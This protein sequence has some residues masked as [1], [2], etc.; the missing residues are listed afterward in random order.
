MELKKFL[1]FSTATEAEKKFTTEA[2]IKEYE[3]RKS[4]ILRMHHL[5]KSLC[6]MNCRASNHTGACKAMKKDIEHL[7]GIIL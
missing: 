1:G 5:R 2:E 7:E 3:T 4:I 6:K